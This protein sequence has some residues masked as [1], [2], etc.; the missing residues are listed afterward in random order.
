MSDTPNINV[1][2]KGLDVGS[3]ATMSREEAIEYAKSVVEKAASI[4]PN[5]VVSAEVVLVTEG[6][7]NDPVQ[8]ARFKMLLNGNV[9]VQSARS[10]SIK[11]AIERAQNDLERQSRK[12]KEKKVGVR[13]R[14]SCASKKARN[15]RAKDAGDI[16][17]EGASA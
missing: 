12:L 11:K 10:R 4:H 6:D 3:N 8:K 7:P 13:Q 1:N 9:L 2:A 17:L 14:K 15:A 5:A 16:F